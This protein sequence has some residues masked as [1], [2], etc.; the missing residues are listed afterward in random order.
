MPCLIRRPAGTWDNLYEVSQSGTRGIVVL[1]E[2][3][4]KVKVIYTA[5]ESGGNI[6]YRES[7]TSSISFGSVNTL[8]SGGTYNNATSTKQN[9][10]G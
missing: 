9:Y 3:A 4:G 5:S 10:S 8:I 7:S 6:L 1:N 2:A